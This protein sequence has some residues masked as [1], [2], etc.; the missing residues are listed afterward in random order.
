MAKYDRK[1]AK[2]IGQV[3]RELTADLQFDAV[4]GLTLGADPVATAMMAAALVSATNKMPS[5]PKVSWFIERKAG[6]PSLRLSVSA[7]WAAG[8]R[9]PTA[10][11]PRVASV[12]TFFIGAMWGW[13]W[14]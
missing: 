8:A 7:A 3:M 10:R 14:Q 13:D 11:A 1:A 9:R 12:E 4:G 2:K 6:L 5:G